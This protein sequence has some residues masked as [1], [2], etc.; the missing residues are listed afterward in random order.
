MEL[1]QLKYF[2]ALAES[3]SF[4]QAAE[5]AAVSQSALSRSIARLEEELGAKLFDRSRKALPLTR[6]GERFLLHAQRAL[7]ELETARRELHE[8][9][10]RDAGTLS[11]SFAHSLGGYHLPLLLSEFHAKYPEVRV[12][13]SQHN[14]VALVKQL[15][16]G[17]TDLCLCP[18]VMSEAEH[19]AWSYL[20][21][22]KL[23]VTVPRGHRLAGRRSVNLKE[24]EGEPFITMKPP[25]SLRILTEQFLKM[26]D[27]HPEIVFAGDDVNTLASLVA[28]GLGVSLIP[29]IEGI[30]KEV[31][32]IPVSYPVC[33]RSIGIAWN[34]E[35]PLPEAAMTFQRFVM[36]R[37]AAENEKNS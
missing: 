29:R 18:T 20:W 12:R 5:A 30:E 6:A 28:A 36:R 26:A 14:T 32:F 16:R 10:S 27:S 2:R 31:V 33:Q 34:T 23:Y 4:T 13:L 35:K 8:G 17:R 1:H 19:V 7:M 24:I 11:L 9:A 25:Y 37:F 22:E 15:S 21:S 3:H